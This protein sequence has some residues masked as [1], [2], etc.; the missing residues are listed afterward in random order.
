MRLYDIAN[1]YLELLQAIEN[2]ELPVE[3]VAD[4]LE[5]IKGELD[6]KADNIGC[7]LKSIE[8]DITAIKT[9]EQRLAERRKTKEK[10]Y[11]RLKQYLSDTLQGLGIG[12]V[13]TARNVITFRKSEVAEVN[14]SAFLEWAKA[15]RVDLITVKVTESANKTEIKK[16]L[17]AGT[18]IP[19]AVLVTKNNLQLK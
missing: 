5:A 18:E 8:A 10:A 16:E 3:A 2:D 15:N 11:D 9:E 7:L 12:K 6:E 19:G 1:D 13:E 17:K 14:E 4:T